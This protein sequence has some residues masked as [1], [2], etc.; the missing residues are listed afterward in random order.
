MNMSLHNANDKRT[1]TVVKKTHEGGDDV[2]HASTCVHASPHSC[3]RQQPPGGL[4][5][6]HHEGHPWRLCSLQSDVVLPS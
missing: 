5:W 6:D 3:P 1:I 4:L 2:S